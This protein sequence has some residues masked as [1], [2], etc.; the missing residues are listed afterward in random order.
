MKIIDEILLHNKYQHRDLWKKKIDSMKEIQLKTILYSLSINCK[1]KFD[2]NINFEILKVLLINWNGLSVY[3]SELE[4]P[5][6]TLYD[7]LFTYLKKNINTLKRIVLTKL[8]QNEDTNVDECIVFEGSLRTLKTLFNSRFDIDEGKIYDLTYKDVIRNDY[9]F[10]PQNFT[11]WPHTA[12]KFSI[13]GL[14]ILHEN[15]NHYEFNVI[16]IDSKF[17]K[18]EI[19]QA[20][21]TKLHFLPNECNKCVQSS[22]IIEYIHNLR[23][24]IMRKTC[25]LPA[26]K[27]VEVITFL[28]EFTYDLRLAVDDIGIG[29]S[30]FAN[31]CP[32]PYVRYMANT[33]H[34]NYPR[35]RMSRSEITV[36]LQQ[37]VYPAVKFCVSKSPTV[38]GDVV[39]LFKGDLMKS[40]TYYC[41]LC[42]SK[43][44]TIDFVE[45]TQHII[46]VHGTETGYVCV[47]CDRSFTVKIL[48]GNRWTH[49]CTPKL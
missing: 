38:V 28:N 3:H 9:N 22:S 27:K 32:F 18:P 37:I 30:Y 13:N 8:T 19:E 4:N 48:S 49:A 26:A 14:E 39:P 41:T 29:V 16:N 35:G 25:D 10:S 5:T 46:N 36:R 31:F 7:A 24:R 45:M 17:Y 1:N 33:N 47:R 15:Y 43:F 40:L 6:K 42:K 34:S 44:E 11:N 21:N 12:V 20:T 2:E 23:T